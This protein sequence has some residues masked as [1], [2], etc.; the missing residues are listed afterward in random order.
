MGITLREF[1]ELD[2]DINCNI[3]I[4][5]CSDGYTWDE[6]PGP[7]LKCFGTSL[8][9]KIGKGGIS[10]Y[11]VRYMTINIATRAIVIEVER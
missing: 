5:D 11:I 4:Y 6:L 3:E 10:D 1:C 2:F 8:P 7:V 9:R